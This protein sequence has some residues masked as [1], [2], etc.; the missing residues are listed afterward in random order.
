MPLIWLS[1]ESSKNFFDRLYSLAEQIFT[2]VLDS[3][4]LEN[5]LCAIRVHLT[6]AETSPFFFKVV[7]SL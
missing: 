1:A 5:Y 4:E 3:A 2:S 6:A 7:I